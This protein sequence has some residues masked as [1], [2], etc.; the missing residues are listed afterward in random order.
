M[1]ITRTTKKMSQ[2]EFYNL[3]N[4]LDYKIHVI[5]WGYRPD[6]DRNGQ[7]IVYYQNGIPVKADLFQDK[8]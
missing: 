3:T 2:V 1:T 8:N 5:R 4:E 7:A 6:D